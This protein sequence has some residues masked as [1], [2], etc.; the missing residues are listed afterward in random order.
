V[1]RAN[2]GSHLQLGGGVHA[3]IGQA[4]VRMELQIA[5]GELLSRFPMLQLAVR[6]DELEWQVEAQGEWDLDHIITMPR[7]V[8]VSW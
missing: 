3:C 6:E 5:L 7:A 4:L 8:P 1:T 2:A